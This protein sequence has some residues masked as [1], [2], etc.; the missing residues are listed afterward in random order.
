MRSAPF[1]HLAVASPLSLDVW[2]SFLA[3]SRVF[4]NSCL[5]INCDSHVL[6]RRDEHTSFCSTNFLA[7]FADCLM[8]MAPCQNSFD[9]LDQDLRVRRDME[10]M[11]S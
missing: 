4:V 8:V 1:Y 10:F 6:V 9:G 7:L 11:S 5:A 3:G 2:L